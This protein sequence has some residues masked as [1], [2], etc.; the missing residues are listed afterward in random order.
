MW[1]S[2]R[3]EKRQSNAKNIWSWKVSIKEK[4]GNVQ[5]FD[6]ENDGQNKGKTGKLWIFIG[7]VRIHIYDFGEILAV[8]WNAR[9]TKTLK[10]LTEKEDVASPLAAHVKGQGIM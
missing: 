1:W 8:S 4:H 5:T 10:S 9:R 7:N 3:R 2:L 6:L